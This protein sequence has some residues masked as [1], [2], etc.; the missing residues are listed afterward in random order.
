ML[1]QS[2]RGGTFVANLRRLADAEAVPPDAFVGLDL[3]RALVEM[4]EVVSASHPG[5]IISMTQSLPSDDQAIVPG[6][7]HIENVIFEI[8]KNLVEDTPGNSVR[9]SI[10]LRKVKDK[11]GRQHWQATITRF[12]HVFPPE[13]IAEAHVIYDPKRGTGRG[14]A[15]SY[16]FCSSIVSHFGGRLWIENTQKNDGTQSSRVIIELPTAQTL[17]SQLR[18]D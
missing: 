14:I 12:G 4:E 5:K 17:I 13:T 9:L 6:G 7:V 18:G 16:A 11:I 2:R 1:K 8:L 15:S 10:A 3:A